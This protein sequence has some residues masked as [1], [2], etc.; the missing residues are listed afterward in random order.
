MDLDCRNSND[1]GSMANNRDLRIGQQPDVY[2]RHLAEP[3]TS[4]RWASRRWMS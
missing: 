2:Q 1:T 3:I 4:S